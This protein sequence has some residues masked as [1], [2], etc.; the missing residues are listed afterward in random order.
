MRAGLSLLTPLLWVLTAALLSIGVLWI[1]ARWLLLTE[2][3]TAWLLARLP[4]VTE[5]RGVQGA[6]LGPRWQAES[7]RLQW[8]G[9]RQSLVLQGLSSEGMTWTWRP[10][11]AG[12]NAGGRAA[13]L[14]T[15]VGVFLDERVPGQRCRHIVDQRKYFLCRR[16]D[17]Q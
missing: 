9:G 17:Q 11:S 6:L 8:D 3:G 16:I 14:T 1:A 4:M 10:Q 13:E 15:D 2:D 12:A 7:L 5:A